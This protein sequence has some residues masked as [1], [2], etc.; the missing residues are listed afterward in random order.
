MVR[1]D[2]VRAHRP[3]HA[4]QARQRLVLPPDPEGLLGRLGEAELGQ[5][6][7]MQLRPF[8]RCGRIAHLG[9]PDDRERLVQLRA[10][11][12]LP[13]LAARGDH[14]V[15]LDAVLHPV[16]REGGTVFVVGMRCHAHQPQP[17]A[18]VEPR[19]VQG[20]RAQVAPL[21]RGAQQ[22]R[23]HKTQWG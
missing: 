18:Q 11:L 13:A 2:D 20:H 4:H 12:V 5:V 22:Q 3:D 10:N 19:L 16:Q 17:A 8:D 9:G 15:C 1:D 14:R 23:R 7:K 21:G 6:E